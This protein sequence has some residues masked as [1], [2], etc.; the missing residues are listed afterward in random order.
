MMQEADML[1]KNMHYFFADP[2]FSIDEVLEKQ[3]QMI[4]TE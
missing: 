1:D 3:K 2:T 4:E